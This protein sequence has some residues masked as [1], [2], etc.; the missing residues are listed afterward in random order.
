M[1]RDQVFLYVLAGLFVFML[2]F[3]VGVVVLAIVGNPSQTLSLRVVGAL[4]SMFASVVGLVLGYLVGRNGK[5]G[6]NAGS[7]G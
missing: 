7:T 6:S 3:G 2:L 1:S 5:N 4:G